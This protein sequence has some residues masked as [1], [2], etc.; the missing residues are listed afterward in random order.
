MPNRRTSDPLIA[1]G[2]ALEAE[3]INTANEIRALEIER[4]KDAELAIEIT[5]GRRWR[6]NASSADQQVEAERIENDRKVREGEIRSRQSLSIIETNAAAQIN[7]TE[8]ENDRQ[9]EAN[10]IEI[11]KNI[12]SLTV[13]R[14]K[15]IRISNEMSRLRTGARGHP[16]ALQRRYRAPAQGRGDLAQ[17]N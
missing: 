10:R 12:E 11:K 16:Q 15:Q 2:R 17:R 5:R 9:V 13:E 14:D 7:Q 3:R 4:Q 8:I 1:K 6:P